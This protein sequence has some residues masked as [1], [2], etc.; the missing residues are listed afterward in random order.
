M[1]SKERGLYSLSNVSIVVSIDLICK[2]KFRTKNAR[3]VR[4]R[5][6][7]IS[8]IIPIKLAKSANFTQLLSHSL[9]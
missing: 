3:T 7:L 9:L 6:E 2:K 4:A 5:V 8:S 1:D